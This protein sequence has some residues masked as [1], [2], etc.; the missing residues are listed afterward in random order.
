MGRK[1]KK[2]AQTSQIEK[3]L[4]ELQNLSDKTCFEYEIIEKMIEKLG[5][6]SITLHETPV[7]YLIPD[8]TVYKDIRPDTI[9][10]LKTDKRNSYVREPSFIKTPNIFSFYHTNGKIVKQKGDRTLEKFL[11]AKTISIVYNPKM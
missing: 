5:P 9:R 2:V 4:Q 7:W 3:Y 11:E 1:N 6:F 10:F 8:Q